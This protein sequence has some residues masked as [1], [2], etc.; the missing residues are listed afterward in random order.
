M[1]KASTLE[2]LEFILESIRLIKSRFKVISS[3]DSFLDNDENIEKLDSISMRLQSIGEALKNLYKRENELLL[4]AGSR[5]Y[6]SEVIKTRD[7][8]SHHYIDLDA[9]IVFDIC[10]NELQ[11]LESKIIELKKITNS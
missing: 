7:F 3:A 4:K 9:E 8:I 6:W 2:L 1:D 5:D 11:T 10:E